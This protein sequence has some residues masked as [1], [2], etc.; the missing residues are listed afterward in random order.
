MIEQTSASSQSL[1]HQ[2]G[3]EIQ[4]FHALRRMPNA[5]SFEARAES[6]QLLNKVLADS[7]ILYNL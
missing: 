7:I 4:E 3:R 1:L 2:K 5:L 6:A